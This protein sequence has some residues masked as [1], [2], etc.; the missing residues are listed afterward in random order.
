MMW[1]F[2]L[3]SLV[4]FVAACQATSNANPELDP[5]FGSDRGAPG[6][7]AYLGWQRGF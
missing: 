6:G 1:K 3:L 7:N 2:A 4:V 5:A